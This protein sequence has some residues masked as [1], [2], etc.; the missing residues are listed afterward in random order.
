MGL[1]PQAK[2]FLAGMEASGAPPLYELPLEEA[3]G[4]TGMITEL[5]GAGPE[6]AMVEDFRC[7]TTTGTIGARSYVPEDAAATILW[8]H[9]GGW[10]ICDLDRSWLEPVAGSTRDGCTCDRPLAL[11]HP[12]RSLFSPVW[13]RLPD[14]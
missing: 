1:D 3:R 7:A 14:A 5:I 9:G 4:A 2:A 11:S 10:V 12:G 6:V 13:F 8:I